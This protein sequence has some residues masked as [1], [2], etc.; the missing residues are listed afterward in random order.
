MKAY[1]V[2]SEDPPVTTYSRPRRRCQKQNKTPDPSYYLGYVDDEE[3]PEMIMKKFE[4]L[5]RLQQSK[6]T[7]KQQSMDDMQPPKTE[8]HVDETMTQ[9]QGECFGADDN[10]D[11]S[12]QLTAEEQ[13]ELFKQTSF[14]TVNM[15]R[16]GGETI[17]ALQDEYYDDPAAGFS[18]LIEISDSE[19]EEVWSDSDEVSV[20]VSV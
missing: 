13:A 16:D 10:R 12:V 5:E 9:G 6:A 8:D 11:S 15:L 18:E 1:Y 2:M 3:T 19:D 17:A 7:Q 20:C 4:A 14:F